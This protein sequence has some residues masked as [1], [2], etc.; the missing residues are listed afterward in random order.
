[1][2]YSYRFPV[3]RGIQAKS[4]YY[5]AMVPLKMLS[6]LF[7]DDTDFVLPEYRAQRRL[8]ESRIPEI[9]NYILRNRGTY[10]FSA[11]AA[12]IDGEHKYMPSDNEDVG[13]LEVS[14]D[15][16]F[17]I[18]DGQH[19]KAAILAA[20]SE[21]STIGEETISVVF[22]TDKGLKRS[23]QMFTDLNKHAVKTSNSIA[24]LY[25][26]RDLLAVVTRKTISENKF[27]DEFVDKERDILGKF[28]SALFTLNTFYNANKR[29]LKRGNC[30]EKFEN[31]LLKY[32]NAVE[33][34]MVPWQD[35]VSRE[36]SKK[37]LREL[38]IASQA[39]V[40]Q[41]LGKVGAYYYGN[42]DE[43][44]EKALVK[45]KTINWKRSAD[46]WK[47]RVIRSNGRMIN[48][49]KAISLTANVI[50]Q[51]IGIPLTNDEKYEE[52]KFQKSIVVMDE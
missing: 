36:I 12:S 21:D 17:L 1:M 45:L 14:M 2:N 20:I 31:F 51:V 16:N 6:K 38:Y 49:E 28:S 33:E 30:D 7:Q 44:F 35:M 25:D 8:N 13:I 27:L 37:D 4:T 24:E 40:I 43:D 22:Y 29:I 42:P 50:K 34:N 19:R 5:I 3:V 26:S 32:W 52:E 46:V 9:K 23:Q 11:L 41:A 39:V 18:N 10:V 47:L 15:A 48:N